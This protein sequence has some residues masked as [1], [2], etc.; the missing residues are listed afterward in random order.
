MPEL[1][2]SPGGRRYGALPQFPSPHDF[3]F[4]R[5][6]LS[7][8]PLPPRTNNRVFCGPV[9]NQGQQGSCAG[10]SECS[11]IEYD[12]RRYKNNAVILS[13]AFAYYM[14]RKIE[15][16]LSQGDCGLQPRSSCQVGKTFGICTEAQMPYSDT[17]FS[18]PPTPA[19]LQE[20]LVYSGNAY[21]LI[22]NGLMD[23]K[24]C[25]NSGYGFNMP[26]M[27]FSSF[28]SDAVAQSGLMPV[29]N[30]NTEECLGGHQPF[31]IDYDDEI[32]CPGASGPG[33]LY[34]QNSYGVEWGQKGFF[35]MPYEV[36]NNSQLVI[37]AYIQHLG[38][39]WRPN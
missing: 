32:E 21:H 4:S 12:E 11:Q 33:T 30:L 38:P 18:T 15:G 10:H 27:V 29:P 7:R 39:P 1:I 34:V 26:F 31:A 28:E 20:A 24:S 5:S 23:M 19:Q 37:A 16:T 17:D 9:K 3:L 36:A 22:L 35:W 2:L 25:M 6:H 14:G 13:P 8:L